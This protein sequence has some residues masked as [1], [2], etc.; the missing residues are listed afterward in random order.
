MFLKNGTIFPREVNGSPPQYQSLKNEVTT[1]WTNAVQK[2]DIST[3][4][5]N[6][7]LKVTAISILNNYK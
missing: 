7:S 5:L 6:W 3:F 4:T 2:F 1:I